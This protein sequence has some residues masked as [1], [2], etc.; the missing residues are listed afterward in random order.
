VN[1]QRNISQP[2]IL[3]VPLACSACFHSRQQAF[4]VQ[5]CSRLRHTPRSQYVQSFAGETIYCDK[6]FTVSCG[7]PFEEFEKVFSIDCTARCQGL[8]VS[9]VIDVANDIV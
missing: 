9:I 3:H 2:M 8:A 6:E 1:V 4:V 5:K 7:V